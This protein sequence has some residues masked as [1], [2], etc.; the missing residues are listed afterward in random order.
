MIIEKNTTSDKDEF[1]ECPYYIA[2]IRR[3]FI[4]TKRQWFRGQ[5]AH[6]TFIVEEMDNTNSIYAFNRFEKESHVEHIQCHFRIA[7]LA[8]DALYVSIGFYNP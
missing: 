8:H 5:Y 7:D 1:Y 4:T 3:R 2:R 6:Y